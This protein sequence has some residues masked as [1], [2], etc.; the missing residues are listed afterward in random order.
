M[1]KFIQQERNSFNF[2]FNGLK[3]LFTEKHF[4]IHLCFAMLAIILGFYLKIDQTE[5]M[6]IVLCIAVVLAA[7]A[8]NTAI[9]KLVDHISLDRTPEAKIIKDIAAGMVLITA[10]ASAVIGTFIFVF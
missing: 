8:A 4:L 10:V 5:W 1:K 6:I 7:E 3:L 2:A 9:E